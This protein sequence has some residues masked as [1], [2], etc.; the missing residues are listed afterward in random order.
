LIEERMLTVL[1]WP[2]MPANGA[3]TAAADRLGCR[4]MATVVASNELLEAQL[5]SSPGT[6]D[7]IFPSD[8]L[9]ERLASSGSLLH[10]DHDSLPLDRLADW[11]VSAQHDPSCQWSVPFAFGTTG[12]LTRDESASSW[13][14]L[15]DPSPPRRVGMLDEVREVVGAALI[16]TGHDPNETSEHALGAARALL[17]HQRPCVARYDSDDFISPVVSGELSIHQAWSG[18]AARVARR[19]SGLHYVVPDE[20]AV[21]WITTAAIPA[22]APDPIAST[23]LLCELMAPELAAWTTIET[24][25]ATPNEAARLELPSE[26]RNDERLFPRAE[27]MAR[28]HPLRDL[29]ERE[30]LLTSQWPVAP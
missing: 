18:P 10:L 26:V 8:Y 1:A 17:T 16:A 28:C 14:E 4:V 13:H 22:S 12:Y 15:F 27:T 11:S 30:K 29:G 24:G 7:L 9:V 3:L 20:G 2:G 21:L 6:F 5:C 19:D 25:F 23:A